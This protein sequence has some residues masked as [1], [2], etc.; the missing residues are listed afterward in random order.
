VKGNSVRTKREAITYKALPDDY[1]CKGARCNLITTAV[2]SSII[3][4]SFCHL[5]RDSA[6]IRMCGMCGMCGYN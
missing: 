6:G 3:G 1:L 4:E 5:L 2:M